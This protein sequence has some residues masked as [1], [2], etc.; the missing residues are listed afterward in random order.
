MIES[1]LVLHFGEDLPIELGF[2]A[3][4]VF[5]EF[6][7][8]LPVFFMLSLEMNLT[9]VVVGDCDTFEREL[10]FGCRKHSDIY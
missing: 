3:N 1:L 9:I 6:G 5:M 10:H 8:M 2:T 4:R 7:E